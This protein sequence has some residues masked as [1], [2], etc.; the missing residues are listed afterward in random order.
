[1]DSFARQLAEILRG[2]GDAI[3][4]ESTPS[5]FEWTSRSLGLHIRFRRAHFWFL[6]VT[7]V[8]HPVALEDEPTVHTH[9]WFVR[10]SGTSAPAA[11]RLADDDYFDDMG[12]PY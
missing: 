3:G 4:L 5:S 2:E 1:V 8:I 9:P 6:I 7:P 10:R 11:R 12:D